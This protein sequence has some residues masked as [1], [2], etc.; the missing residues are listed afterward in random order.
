M[1]GTLLLEIL[2]EELPT[3]AVSELSAAGAEALGAQLQS[4]QLPYTA[5]HRYATPRRLAW[6]V[7]GLRRQQPTQ[8]LERK[9][10]ALGAAQDSAGQW[11]KAALGFAQSCGV[12]VDEL[13]QRD[14]HLYFQREQPGRDLAE[15]FP[16]IFAALTEALPIAKRMRWGSNEQSFVRPVLSLLAL[17]NEEILPLEYFGLRAGNQTLGHRVHGPGPLTIA[18]PDSYLDVL[19]DNGVLADPAER[20]R[21]IRAQIEA[22]AEQQQAVAT[23]EEALLDE[24]T[25]LVEWPVAL[26]G[27]FE[28]E[29]L[30]IPAEVL[31]TTMR[32][33][34]KTFPLFNSAGALLP[35]FIAIANLRSRDEALV[36]KGNEKVIRPRFAD[37][38][39]FWEQDLKRPL[40]DY[41][42]RLAAVSYQA[43]LGTLADK[44]ARLE[45]LTAYLGPLTGADP[46]PLAL[47]ARLS[48]S[49]LLSE[50][51]MEFPELQGVMGAY[52]A[53][54]EGLGPTVAAALRE[55]YQP[56]GAQGS[57]PRTREGLA[58]ALAEKVDVLVGGFA[59]GAKPS[60]SKDPYGL[61]RNAIAL[62]RLIIENELS[63]DLKALL[64]RSASL[65]PAELAA[66][67]VLADL[68]EYIIE[69]LE[70]YY[71]EQN[72]ASEIYQAVKA[73][74][75]NDL[76]DFDRRIKALNQFVRA[77]AA[78]ILL[79]CAK[80]IRNILR[81]NGR[82]EAP[83]EAAL[84][85]EPAEKEL[86]VA[87][88]Q[89]ESS[90]N[91]ALNAVNYGEA[92]H[93]LGT[94]DRHLDSFFTHV[95][96]MSEDKKLQKNRLALLTLLQNKFDLVADLSLI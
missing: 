76:L 58:L 72:I 27:D 29:F 21:S 42:P 73:R 80:R 50:M 11:S 30:R 6:R 71:S 52:Y 25:A 19:R 55:Q 53:E 7:D 10:P 65:F 41:L 85:V 24:V 1:E 62:I 90:L 64:E 5:I 40:A 54:A 84:L 34:Q 31:I 77:G 16:A 94:L 36:K 3:R 75:L 70:H 91:Q 45:A 96:V 47:A 68:R 8:R 17:Y 88:Q 14:G 4:Q 92:L 67:K 9:G 38:Q 95:M 37:A 63:L 49:D 87:F 66:E 43:K 23:V 48:K 61:R 93:L 60:G 35:H 86:F 59:L 74:E 13:E 32:D 20:R 78:E 33:N 18:H 46:A 44:V 51:V 15:L 82:V 26:L 79:A 2:T 83:V 56:L 57:L 81:K 28:P 39:F 69:R 22:L 12:A 89:Q